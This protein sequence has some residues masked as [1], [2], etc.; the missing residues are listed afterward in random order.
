MRKNVLITLLG[1]VT[2]VLLG[3]SVQQYRELQRL[4]ESRAAASKPPATPRR[5]PLA[6]AQTGT[7]LPRTLDAAPVT[8]PQPAAPPLAGLAQ[9]MKSPGMKEMIR[10]QQKAMLENSYGSLFAYLKLPDE[11]VERLKQLLTEKQMAALDA[12][13][14]MMDGSATPEQRAEQGKKMQEFTSRFDKDIEKLLGPERYAVYKEYEETQPERMQVS[15]FKQALSADEPLTDQQEH[16]LIRAMY[17]ERTKFPFT[18]G[19]DEKQGLNPAGFNEEAIAKHL[20]ELA[21]L[22]DKYLAR[23]SNVLTAAQLKQFSSNQEEQRTMQ[24]MGLKMAAQM[25]G[26]STNAQPAAAVA[27]P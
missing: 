19:F 6:P 24:E 3:L 16:D 21:S 22:Q 13:L 2:L 25:F 27:Q 7:P 12:G 26:A 10:A 8:G 11:G 1:A 15:F 17:E 20:Q 9:M 5:A 18:A 4:R 14:E 23:A